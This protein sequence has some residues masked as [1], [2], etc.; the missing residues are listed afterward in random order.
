M[1][2]DRNS[3][4]GARY[5][6]EEAVVQAHIHFRSRQSLW[7]RLNRRI[8]TPDRKILLERGHSSY[9]YFE[10][11]RKDASPTLL[12]SFFRRGFCF[13]A[14]TF[15][16]FRFAFG[17]FGTGVRDRFFRQQLCSDFGVRQEQVE[18][19]QISEPLN[20][21]SEADKLLQQ[22]W[23]LGFF[24]FCL[25]FFYLCFTRLFFLL[26]FNLFLFF[27]MS[28]RA[29]GEFVFPFI[30][31]SLSFCVRFE[32]ADSGNLNAILF[33]LF[34]ISGFANNICQEDM[35]R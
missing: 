25:L 34:N 24:F 29:V 28:K 6:F 10:F 35:Q 14:F 23:L 3:S 8:G 26:L 32:V 4:T 1:E 33:Q 12:H 20:S 22:C 13:A 16:R 18:N 19:V 31:P 7:H 2:K 9:R 11:S 21:V 5:L 30:L 27:T 15:G 17:S